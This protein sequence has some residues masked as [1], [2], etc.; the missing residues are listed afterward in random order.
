[1]CTIIYL[2]PNSCCAENIFIIMKKMEESHGE[3]TE[4]SFIFSQT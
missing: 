2:A 4:D 1:M 3:V